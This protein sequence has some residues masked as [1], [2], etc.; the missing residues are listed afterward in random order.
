MGGKPSLSIILH[1][2]RVQVRGCGVITSSGT[3]SLV[4]G[5]AGVPGVIAYKAHPLTY[6]WARRMIRVPFIGIVNI[7]LDAPIYPEFIQG[8]ATPRRLC[9]AI[10]EVLGNDERRRAAEK[11]QEQLRVLLSSDGR[12]SPG[13]WL[14]DAMDGI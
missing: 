7:L 1:A 9:P 8:R 11:A 2:L 5:L 12:R 4:C 3:M 13:F 14:A 10:L 6:L